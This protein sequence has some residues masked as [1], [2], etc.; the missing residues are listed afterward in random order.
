MTTTPELTP[1]LTAS[2]GTGQDCA[3]SGFDAVHYLH[4]PGST[5]VVGWIG[6]R[7]RRW[8]VRLHGIAE[9]TVT[10]TA[11]AIAWVNRHA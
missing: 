8:N 7:N 4:R 6:R 1:R 3:A 5:A 9:T 2:I 10:T 11:E